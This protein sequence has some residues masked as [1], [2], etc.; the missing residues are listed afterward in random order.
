MTTTR[1]VCRIL[2]AGILTGCLAGCSTSTPSTPAAHAA[3]AAGWSRTD[4][5]PVSQPVAAGS[6]F[7]VFTA[8][9]GGLDVVGLDPQS[10]RTLWKHAASPSGITPG[11]S[12]ELLVVDGLV[13]YPSPVSQQVVRL[14]AA[15]P[16]TGKA[17]W[18]TQPG[19]LTSWPEACPGETQDICVTGS[20]ASNSQQTQLLRFSA[21]NGSSLASPVLSASGQGARELAPGLFDPGQRNPELMLA[22]PGSTVDWTKPLTSIVSLPGAS[23]DNGWNLDRIARVGLFVGSVAAPLSQN[24]GH[25]VYDLSNA[26]TVGIRMS[27]GSVAWQN[28]GSYY[29]CTILPCAGGSGAGSSGSGAG[30]E[31]G[32]TVGVRTRETGTLTAPSSASGDP[33]VSPGA[34]VTLEGFD[35]ATGHTLWAFHA[36]HDVDLITNEA[37]PPQ[38]GTSE[39]LLSNASGQPTALNLAT[40]TAETVSASVVA[41]CQ[42]ATFYTESVPYQA[43]ST[44]IHQY[45]GDYSV[46]P[47][48]SAM[49]AVGTPARIPSFVGAR[50]GETSAWSEK[51]KVVAA[52]TAAP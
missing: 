24:G 34:T 8:V 42:S 52:A 29:D 37:L 31:L 15:N 17:V 10:G 35:P 23:T 3:Q 14:V 48:D 18:Q 44:S 12:P 43:A 1:V 21:T 16:R 13:V 36:G 47:C 38:V 4:L 39:I 46:F 40:G 2:A 9:H 30:A 6:A 7:V 19:F 22:S 32:P 26:S 11:V 20:V 27:D 49:H 45:V 41:W 28:Q 50:I 25:Q 5:T 33:V 51:G